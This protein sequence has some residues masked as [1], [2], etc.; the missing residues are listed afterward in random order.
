MKI[1][2]LKDVGGAGRVGEVKEIA[3]GYA[4]NF[5][6]PR[7]LA[8]QATPEKISAH[9]KRV[10]SDVASKKEK[11]QKLASAVHS[12]EGARI[13]LKVRATEKGGLFKA[14]TVADIIKLLN[15]DI[16]EDAVRL[17]KP[18]KKTGE[19]KIGIVLGTAKAEITLAIIAKSEKS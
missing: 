5:L 12:L 3:N 8:E 2:F 18:I 7:G 13:E 17:E 6:I 10:A 4:M 14:V 15:V 19:Y 16:P 9:E 11:E 1:I